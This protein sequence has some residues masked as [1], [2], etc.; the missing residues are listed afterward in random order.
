VILLLAPPSRRAND[1]AISLRGPAGDPAVADLIACEAMGAS[2]PADK[3]ARVRSAI[4]HSG[5]YDCRISHSAIAPRNLQ[6]LDETLAEVGAAI[7]VMDDDGNVVA[8]R[9]TPK[10]G[11]IGAILFTS[12]HR[13]GRTS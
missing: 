9:E 7:L 13:T 1:V 12:R 2:C 11:T 4:L 6:H 3:A 8:H 5:R 10:P